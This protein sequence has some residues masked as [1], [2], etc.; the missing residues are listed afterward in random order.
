[1]KYSA[2]VFLRVRHTQLAE[3]RARAS[4]T[5]MGLTP[6]SGLARPVRLEMVMSSK[7]AGSAVPALM[8]LTTV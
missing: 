1:M 2:K 3:R 5:A 7:R 6:P 4:P 8:A